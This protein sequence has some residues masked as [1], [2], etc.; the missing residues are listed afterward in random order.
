M[1]ILVTG[2]CGNM[3]PHIIRKLSELG[4]SVR[5]IDLDK[6][7]LKQFENTPVETVCG[8][9][10]NRELVWSAIK[11]VDAIIHLAW[12]FSAS[13]AELMD[14]DI[15]GYLNLLD[16]AVACNVK[17]VINTTTAVSYGKPLSKP[18]N[19]D[20][21]HQVALSRGP[22]YALAKLTTEELSRIYAREHGLQV[23][24]MMVWYAFGDVIGGRNLR[25]M[26][27]DAIV[28]GEITIPAGS[29]GSFIQLDDYVTQALTIMNSDIKGELFN[30]V[31]VYLTWEDVAQIIVNRYA[32]NAKVNAIPL[33]QWTGS[34][35]LTDDWPLSTEKSEK[36]LGFKS[37]MTRE[38]AM[39]SLGKA[40]DAS[41]ARVRREL[42]KA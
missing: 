14:I 5:T 37:A 9:L 41:A 22:A 12:S 32:P 24:S 4:H 1:K 40:L 11:G 26:I 8:N 16:A 36:M 2:G 29:G 20:Q 38:E 25:A 34:V 39:E 23:N 21:A 3:G 35:F 15:K 28:K 33:E 31:T 19:E 13:F 18:V 7:G 17:H 10:N 27:K 30:A 6:E 42:A